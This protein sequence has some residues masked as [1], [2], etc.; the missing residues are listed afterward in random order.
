MAQMT[1]R[2]ILDFEAVSVIIPGAST[3]EQAR[4]N[5]TVSDLPPLSDDLHAFLRG[6]YRDGVHQHVRGAY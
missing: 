3:P 1:Q 2:W 4:E 6:F 5:A